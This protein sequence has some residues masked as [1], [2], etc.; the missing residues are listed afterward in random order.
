M[1]RRYGAGQDRGQRQADDTGKGQ[2]SDLAGISL[3]AA[4]CCAIDH[5]TT[6]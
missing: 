3:Q 4:D 2:P 1:G 6:P 5:A